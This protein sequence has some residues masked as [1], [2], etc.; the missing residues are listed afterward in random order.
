MVDGTQPLNV[1]FY[2]PNTDSTI[3]MWIDD[4]VDDTQPVRLAHTLHNHN[5][6]TSMYPL[7]AS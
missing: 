3:Y 5:I 2:A 4:L 1:A 7:D 6:H